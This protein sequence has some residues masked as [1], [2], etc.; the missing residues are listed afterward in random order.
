M[1][2]AVDVGRRDRKGSRA[3]ATMARKRGPSILIVE[4]EPSLREFLIRGLGIA[5]Y[6]VSSAA[7]G[8]AALEALENGS[9]DLLITDIVMPK[10]DGIAL[11]LKAAKDWP[12]MKILMMTGYAHERMRA[13]NLGVL[14][15]D[16]IAK[17]FTLDQIQTIV[18]T[19]LAED[20][21]D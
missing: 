16:I 3:M 5:G 18:A 8:S 10:L 6:Q 21:E 2:M 9:F 20:D 7:D 1:T 17:P 19:V 13:H 14:S 15:H 4:D 11:A 12:D